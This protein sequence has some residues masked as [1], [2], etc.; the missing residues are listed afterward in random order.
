M[1]SWDIPQESV[2]FQIP[3]KSRLFQT[4]CNN[5]H[6]LLRNLAT[7]CHFRTFS[8]H[9][10]AWWNIKLGNARGEKSSILHQL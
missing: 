10:Q 3:V 6:A 5:N 4:F 8:E 2:N 7:A 1:G 9:F